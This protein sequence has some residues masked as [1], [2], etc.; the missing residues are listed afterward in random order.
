MRSGS[1]FAPTVFGLTVFALKFA[2]GPAAGRWMDGA[3]RMHVIKTGILWQTIGVLGALC[4]FGLLLAFERRAVQLADLAGRLGHRSDLGAFMEDEV[5]TRRVF[6]RDRQD[7]AN[8]LRRWRGR[9]LERLL[10]R[11]IAL[12][13][14]LL[15]DSQNSELALA[16][17]L[18]EIARAAGR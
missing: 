16:Q 11:L 15:G 10:A 1:L 13:R 18:A 9:K 5:S 3:E 8:Q 4:V 17:G 12:H 14:T 6:F 7:I 2:C